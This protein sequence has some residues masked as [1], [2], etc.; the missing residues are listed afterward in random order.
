MA[1]PAQHPF[2]SDHRIPVFFKGWPTSPSC[3]CSLG[4]IPPPVPRWAC[5]PGL[6]LRENCIHSLWLYWLTWGRAHEPFWLNMTQ[7]Y[8]LSLTVWK[9]AC[10]HLYYAA[11]S[12]S[13]AAGEKHACNWRW[14]AELRGGNRANPKAV[15]ASESRCAP[16]FLCAWNLAINFLKPLLNLLIYF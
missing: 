13:G 11:E 5:C 6:L 3:A 1:L 9:T 10:F 7:F 15:V 12:E 8:D 4:L 14:K 2:P 16:N